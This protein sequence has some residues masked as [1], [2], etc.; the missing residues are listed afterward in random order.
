M[1]ETKFKCPVCGE[2][3]IVKSELKTSEDYTFVSNKG[4]YYFWIEDR[5]LCKCGLTIELDTEDNARFGH[6]NIRCYRS[7]NEQED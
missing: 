4:K 1:I 6:I 5:I 3:H 2:P 7:Q